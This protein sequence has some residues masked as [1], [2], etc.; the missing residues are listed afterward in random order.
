[1]RCD[2]KVSSR[3]LLSVRVANCKAVNAHFSNLVHCNCSW[4]VQE[5]HQGSIHFDFFVPFY[6]LKCLLLFNSDFSMPR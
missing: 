4:E 2:D 6:C 5:R 3:L 1:M